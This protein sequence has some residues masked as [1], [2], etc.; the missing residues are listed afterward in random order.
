MNF[1][2]GFGVSHFAERNT[3]V[4]LEVRALAPPD[5]SNSFVLG[6]T[7]LLR[8]LLIPFHQRKDVPSG[9]LLAVV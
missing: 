2:L 1:S 7:T 5:Q 6:P 3:D 8:S 4:L 9:F